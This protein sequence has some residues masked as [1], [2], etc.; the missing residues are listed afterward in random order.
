MVK[1]IEIKVKDFIRF[2]AMESLNLIALKD[3]IAGV[4]KVL[5]NAYDQMKKTKGEKKTK[6]L[7]LNTYSELL[8]KSGAEDNPELALQILEKIAELYID[9]KILNGQPGKGSEQ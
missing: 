7:I 5:N 2:E 6:T 1:T 9:L 8:L 4:N 3:G